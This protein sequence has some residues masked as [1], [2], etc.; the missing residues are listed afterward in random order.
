MTVAELLQLLAQHKP[1]QE[2]FLSLFPSTH[3]VRMNYQI[4]TVRPEGGLVFLDAVEY[5]ERESMP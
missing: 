1:D 4:G 2:V 5:D 3:L